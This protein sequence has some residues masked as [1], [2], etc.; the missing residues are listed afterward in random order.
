MNGALGRVRF[1]AIFRWLVSLALLPA[2]QLMSSADLAAQ[3]F[4]TLTISAGMATDLATGRLADYWK[5]EPGG[6]L[7]VATPFYLGDIA[8]A[9]HRTSFPTKD[10]ARPDFHLLTTTIEWNAELGLP[11]G[12][13]AFGGAQVGSAAMHFEDNDDIAGNENE[14]EFLAGIQ[15]GVEV[16]IARGVGFTVVGSQRRIFTRIPMRL[17]SVGA[18]LHVTFRTPGRLREILE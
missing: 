16:P 14:N 10:A 9:A 4:S 11:R 17:T 12:A 7:R 13:A 6:Y 1:S 15:A 5:T 2:A 3:P 18:G 8:L